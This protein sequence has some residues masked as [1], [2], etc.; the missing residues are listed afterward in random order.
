M[1]LSQN[2]TQLVWK[3]FLHQTYMLPRKFSHLVIWSLL[4][5]LSL[6][7]R[8][9]SWQ[10]VLWS[11]LS[12]YQKELIKSDCC[13]SKVSNAI[14]IFQ[15]NERQNFTNWVTLLW[16]NPS[17]LM[18]GCSSLH[19]YRSKD[20]LLLLLVDLSAMCNRFNCDTF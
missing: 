7:Q 4:Q 10:R 1:T 20:E 19:S 15:Q 16:W 6:S 12:H 2:W 18:M 5:K 14:K 13:K 17:V 11:Y 9:L 3:C 8:K